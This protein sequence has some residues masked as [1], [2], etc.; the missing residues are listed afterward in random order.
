MA[1][2]EAGII[3]IKTVAN[4]FKVAKKAKCP[5]AV[6]TIKNSDRVF[7]RFMFKRIKVEMDILGVIEAA[8]VERL[9]TQE[10]SDIA[11]DMMRENLAA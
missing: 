11:Y 9:S 2:E 5:V 8:D 10:I 4:T 3:S 6:M 7:R 1:Q